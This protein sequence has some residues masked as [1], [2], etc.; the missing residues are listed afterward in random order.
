MT[1]WALEG[2]RN[3]RTRAFGSYTLDCLSWMG[4]R[5]GIGVLGNG[6]SS[7]TGV[8]G[9][10]NVL[11]YQ[12]GLLS[13]CPADKLEL[14]IL[15]THFALGLCYISYVSVLLFVVFLCDFCVSLHS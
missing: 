1:I 9:T 12:W 3:C 4:T 6:G 2:F 5:I 14:K 11:G 10:P 8:Y 13:V 15:G 7:S